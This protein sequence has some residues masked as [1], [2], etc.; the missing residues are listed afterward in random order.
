M[1]A[2]PHQQAYSQKIGRCSAA[3]SCLLSLMMAI[4]KIAP[5]HTGG[6]I[7]TPKHKPGA[8]LWV[9]GGAGQVGEKWVGRSGECGPEFVTAN[10]LGTL[11]ATLGHPR[12]VPHKQGYWGQRL[13]S[14]S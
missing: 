13:W 9:P 1:F 14:G 8:A 4:P 2:N 11:L 10:D 12:Y 7:S 3:T 6:F 5:S